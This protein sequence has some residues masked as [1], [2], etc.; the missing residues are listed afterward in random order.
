VLFDRTPTTP[1]VPQAD[2][3]TVQTPAG[4]PPTTIRFWLSLPKL[5]PG[6]AAP[7]A[8]LQHGFTQWRGEMTTL[9][10]NLAQAGWAAI[11]FDL[12]LHGARAVCTDDAQCNGGCSAGV[13]MGGFRNATDPLACALEPLSGDPL[14][15]NPASSGNGFIDPADLFRTRSNGQQFVLDAAQAVRV[16]R[17]TG[18][19]SLGA[20]LPG[21]IDGGRIVYLGH[22]LGAMEGVL[23]N[24]VDPTP[25]VAVFNAAAG[26]DFDVL[27]AG[28]FAPLLDQYLA[29]IGVQRGTPAYAQLD[30]TA[31]WVLDA[32][33]PVVLARFVQRMPTTS[34]LTGKPN[35]SKPVLQQETGLDMVLPPPFQEAL[36]LQLFGPMGLDANH[37]LQSRRTDGTFVSSYFPTATHGTLISAQPMSEGV[38]MR[39][40]ATTFI[41]A[42]G[43]VLPAAH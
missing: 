26:K 20:Q 1:M 32:V 41:A 15:C 28:S 22:S 29:S 13:C 36:G 23:F 12:D 3:F 10:D 25:G 43:A 7:I 34:Y 14:D 18:A 33:D 38:P 39:V 16:L 42:G 8:I 19:G 37:H 2:L 30:A 35:P 31:T 27:A 4:D 21:A 9:A 6:S 11:A 17:A 5:P 40:Q 24:A